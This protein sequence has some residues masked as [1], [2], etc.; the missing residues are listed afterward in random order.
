MQKRTHAPARA[1]RA[2]CTL[3]L[4]SRAPSLPRHTPRHHAKAPD[5]G[6]PAP[7]AVLLLTLSPEAAAARGEYGEERYE[8]VDF[9]KAVR[10]RCCAALRCVRVFCVRVCKHALTHPGACVYAFP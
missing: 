4:R 9:Q 8:R 2:R 7:D 10:L 1:A 5:R 3:A 6:L